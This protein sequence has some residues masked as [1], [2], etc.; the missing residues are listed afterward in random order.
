MAF[1]FAEM[2]VAIRVRI[3]TASLPNA[4]SW[5]QGMA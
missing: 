5:T 2:R 1:M 4:I 3:D